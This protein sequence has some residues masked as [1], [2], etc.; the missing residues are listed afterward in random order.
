MLT[1]C[2]GFLSP[3]PM[4]ERHL[5]LSLLS[6]SIVI[7]FSVI[8]EYSKLFIA[9]SY[10]RLMLL[11]YSVLSRYH[12]KWSYFWYSQ[13][14]VAGYQPAREAYIKEVTPQ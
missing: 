3:K 11:L 2:P 12:G 1:F 10:L 13:Q 7:F 9:L 14:R 8:K 4:K 5:Q 6:F